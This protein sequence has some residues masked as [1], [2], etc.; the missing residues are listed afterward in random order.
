MGAV[1]H[2]KHTPGPWRQEGF[3]IYRDWQPGEKG[4][5]PYIAVQSICEVAHDRQGLR[6]GHEENEANARLIAEAPAMR[7]LLA[8]I[9]QQPCEC[10]RWAL[11]EGESDCN[12]CEARTLLARIDG[13]EG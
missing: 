10:S 7:T 2:P 9:A 1:M 13:A 4:N 5:L 6:R 12:R 11:T 8:V 3:R